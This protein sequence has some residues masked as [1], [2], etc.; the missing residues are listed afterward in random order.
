MAA[1]TPATCAMTGRTPRPRWVEVAA[2]GC[3]WSSDVALHVRRLLRHQRGGADGV[4]HR[5][6]GALG[7]PAHDALAGGGDPEGGHRRGAV[8]VHPLRAHRR[9]Q[10]GLPGRARPSP[11]QSG[12]QAIGAAAGSG[13]GGHAAGPAITPATASTPAAPSCAAPACSTGC[14]DPRP[15]LE[16]SA[17]SRAAPASGTSSWTARW[18]ATGSPSRPEVFLTPAATPTPRRRSP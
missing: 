16:A 13:G 9:L 5:G 4:G 7:T 2:P 10:G 11:E 12:A 6:P 14:T 3:T 8:P 1:S 18:P 15:H 17:R